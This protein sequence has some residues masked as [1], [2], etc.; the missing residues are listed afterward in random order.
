VI[1]LCLVGREPICQQGAIPGKGY[2]WAM[3]HLDEY[4]RIIMLIKPELER[5]YL[6]NA[7]GLFGSVVRDDFS[8]SRSDI[9][10]IVDFKAPVGIEF[11]ELA[12]YLEQALHHKVDLVSRNGLKPAYFK[13]IAPDIVYV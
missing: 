4:K 2:F 3:K 12:D 6:V 8:P 10:V 11:I 7:I 9:D 13:A 1:R 5:K